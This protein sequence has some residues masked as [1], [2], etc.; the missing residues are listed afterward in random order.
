LNKIN[1]MIVEG[2]KKALFI[3]SALAYAV[4]KEI[5]SHYA[6]LEGEVDTIILTG[7]IFDSDR[8]LENVKKRIGKIAPIA[9]YPSVNDFEAL[10]RFGMMIMKNEVA[11]KKY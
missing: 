6:T 9:L 11:V 8:F 7:M 1:R 4:S 3:S 2:D 10:A 5:A